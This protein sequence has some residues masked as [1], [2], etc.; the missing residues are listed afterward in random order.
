[1]R[2]FFKVLLINIACLFFIKH[3]IASQQTNHKLEYS[4]YDSDRASD[5]LARILDRIAWEQI[6]DSESDSDSEE[7]LSNFDKGHSSTASTLYVSAK[8]SEDKSFSMDGSFPNSSSQ[9]DQSV[10][11]QLIDA[12]K[13][14][15][16]NASRYW[17]EN[18]GSLPYS[19]CILTDT[20]GNWEAES[21]ASLLYGRSFRAASGQILFCYSDLEQTAFMI[22]L[23]CTQVYSY[24]LSL[25]LAHRRISSKL[26]KLREASADQIFGDYSGFGAGIGMIASV[27]GARLKNS[28]NSIELHI[29]SFISPGIIDVFL[30]YRQV[31]I[32]PRALHDFEVYRMNSL[33][34]SDRHSDSKNFTRTAAYWIHTLVPG[35]GEQHFFVNL[36]YEWLAHLK[37]VKRK[38]L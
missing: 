34:S 5:T 38:K 3:L 8:Q 17:R 33:D 32:V 24:G 27:S 12:H 4:H 35:F 6:S 26:V 36:E 23:K 10:I 21:R 25:T 22:P 20:K 16:L 28:K 14:Q 31:S 9:Q 1:M 15:P 11:S 18:P 13:L 37:F 19:Q 7:I 29:S 30:A 2:W